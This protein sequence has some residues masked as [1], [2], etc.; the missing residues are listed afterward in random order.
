MESN[1]ASLKWPFVGRH[2]ELDEFRLAWADPRCQGAVIHGPSGVGKTRLAEEFLSICSRAGYT[3]IRIKGSAAARTVPLGAIAHLLPP[4]VDLSDPIKGFRDVV[5]TLSRLGGRLALLVDDLHL[6]DSPSAMLLRQLLD[7]QR[8]RIVGTIRS[9]ENF[10]DAVDTL[11]G[12]DSIHWINLAEFSQGQLEETLRAALG[13]DVGRSAIHSLHAA[14]HG[15]VLYLR[16]LVHGALANGT[17]INDGEIWELAE[18]WV[19][20]TERLTELIES[21]MTVAADARPLLELL[22][23]CEPL[24]LTESQNVVP[25]DTLTILENTGLT[26]V[27]SN[28][29]RITVALAHPLYGEVI[30]RQIPAG[31]RRRILLEQAE[32]TAAHGARRREDALRIAG[33]R[34]AATGTADP[35]LLLHAATLARYAH[36]YQQVTT[37][38]EAVPEEAQTAASRLLHSEALFERGRPEEAEKILTKNLQQ[39]DSENQKLTATLGQTFNLFWGYGRLSE[40]LGFNDEAISKCTNPIHLHILRLNE[41]WMRIMAND[42]GRGLTLLEEMEENVDREPNINMWMMCTMIGAT[43]LS[44]TGRT[45]EAINWAERGYAIHC[46]VEERVLF[47]PHPAAQLISL[48]LALADS[49]RLREA[50]R[51][52][53]QAFNELVAAR[54]P[55]PRVW[56]AYQLGRTEL[57]AGHLRAARR[58]FAESVS[59]SRRGNHPL[60][61][62]AALSGLA[63][64]D[65]QL[66]HASVAATEIANLPRYP[67]GPHHMEEPLSKAWLL[68]TRG[69]LGR[70]RNALAEGADE[71]RR[72]QHFTAEG[73][74]LTEVARLG[75]PQRTADRLAEL[76]TISDGV[77]PRARARF[78]GALASDDPNQLHKVAQDL[79]SM[80][81]DLLA[82]EAASAAAAIW[83]RSDRSRHATAAAQLATR[84]SDRCEGARTPLINTIVAPAKLSTRELEVARL[85]AAGK[86]STDIAGDLYISVRTVDNHL[87]HVYKKLGVTNRRE[88][89]EVLSQEF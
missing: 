4:D 19:P 40:A 5:H 43:G 8:V 65:A 24:G 45:E 55:A 9:G 62:R 44:N 80:G 17:L 3:V 49:G 28:G 18:G 2:R 48:V 51:I 73:L 70:A 87:Q 85:A 29:L 31:R 25:M 82:A 39:A 67:L 89:A 1:S 75:D 16:E 76:A 58:W 84:C 33:W 69:H 68:A 56:I 72:S 86:A 41:G 35:E 66:A 32:R 7:S 6:L 61:I 83:R 13:G 77:F 74:L 10:S 81:A 63:A 47:P 71:A 50:R 21:R 23:L 88:L 14:T 60:A 57:L 54:A 38:L 30:R 37:L 36:D 27:D 64:C 22:A 78:A 15:N 79:E 20:G 59:L 42:P 26:E 52:G 53:E 11:T 34:L 12:G 46:N